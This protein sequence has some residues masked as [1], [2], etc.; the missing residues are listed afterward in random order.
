MIGLSYI[1]QQPRLPDCLKQWHTL[2][3]RALIP[4][5]LVPTKPEK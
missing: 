3:T 2:R 1:L 4:A 5:R